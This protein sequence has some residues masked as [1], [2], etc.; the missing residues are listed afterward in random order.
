MKRI[1]ANFCMIFISVIT[2]SCDES[3]SPKTDFEKKYVLN[4]IIQAET[5]RQVATL[6]QTYDVEGFNP[7]ENPVDPSVKNADIKIFYNG[8][9]YTMK[10]TVEYREDLLHGSFH[11]YYADLLQVPQKN[12]SIEIAAV[13]PDGIEL[14]AKTQIPAISTFD[15]LPRSI[16]EKDVRFSMSWKSLTENIFFLPR[17]KILYTKL[18]DNPAVNYYEEIPINY[19][20]GKF[21]YPKISKITALNFEPGMIDSAMTRIS[22]G[23][24]NK[25]NYRVI[26]MIFEI[27]VFDQ[28]LSS[29]V[30]S[31]N[32]FFDD[33]SIRLDEP[34]YS[35]IEGGF[36]IFGSYILQNTSI[37]LSGDYVRSFRY[38]Q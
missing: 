25:G 1:I 21:I 5:G 12:G 31:T 10:D 24:P 37:L 4:C 27:I 20:H 28:Y 17:L 35:N 6:S 16:I 23:D 11:Y 34:N 14:S 19:S 9:E 36:G 2:F 13:T 30:S 15:Y 29:Y 33:L 38:V 3:F 7:A 22:A 32:G 18:D 8:R 26:R